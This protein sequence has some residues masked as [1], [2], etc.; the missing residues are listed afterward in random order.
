MASVKSVKAVAV[1]QPCRHYHFGTNKN[2]AEKRTI[3]ILNRSA[4]VHMQMSITCLIQEV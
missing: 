3:M 1:L 2:I 4:H